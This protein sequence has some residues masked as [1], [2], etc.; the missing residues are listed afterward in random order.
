MF[1]PQKAAE[2]HVALALE[3]K[4]E[5]TTGTTDAGSWS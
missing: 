1:Q 4:I 2:H 3:G 5:E